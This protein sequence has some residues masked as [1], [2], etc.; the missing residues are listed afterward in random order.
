MFDE[1]L[2]SQYPTIIMSLNIGRETYVGRILSS[3]DRNNRLGLIDLQQKDPDEILWI[4]NKN[5]RQTKLT[6]KELINFIIENKWTISANG[7]MFRTDIKSVLATILEIWWDERKIYSEKKKKA[8]K[9]N[10]KTERRKWHLM[11]YTFK[12]LLNSAY[13]ALAVPS[14]RFGLPRAIL[15]EATTLTGQRLIQESALCIN[16]HMNK[17]MRNEIKF[18]NLN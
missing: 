16:T 7:V 12:I 11:Q 8:I 6:V 10:N 1:D 5:N 18:G 14:F 9:S 17:I 2:T 13:G 4:E 15:A 3:D